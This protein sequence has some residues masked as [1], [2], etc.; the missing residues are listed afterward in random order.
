MLSL[1]ASLRDRWTELQMEKLVIAHHLPRLA[2]ATAGAESLLRA[3]IRAS[4]IAPSRSRRATCFEAVADCTFT[5][6]AFEEGG[7]TTLS[8][9][10]LSDDDDDDDVYR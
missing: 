8:V 7:A 6:R 3:G 10:V 4:E 1:A 2:A 5:R 9:V